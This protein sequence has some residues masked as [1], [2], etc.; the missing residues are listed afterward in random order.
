MSPHC[1]SNA[2]TL[3]IAQTSPARFLLHA[4]TVKYSLGLS[5]YVLTIKSR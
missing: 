2:C 1:S 3:M 4:V 5:L